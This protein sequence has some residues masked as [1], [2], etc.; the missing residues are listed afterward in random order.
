[1]R[2][3]ELGCFRLCSWIYLWRKEGSLFC[4]VV[5]MRFTELGCFRLCSWIYLWR[6]VV[7]FFCSYYEIHRTGMLQIVFLNLS[8]KE[9][10]LFCFVVMRFTELGCFRS[11]SWCLWK[12]LDEE[13]C[14]G[15][16]SMTFALA[17]QKLLNIEW[18]L[19][20]KLNW[21]VLENFRGIGMC[22]LVLLERSWWAGF[23][24]N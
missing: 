4:F 5:I 2:F 22:L 24:G 17:V 3:A 6:K 10:S 7:C 15:L 9:C 8:M 18:F 19:H 13:G 21:T 20:W 16:G 11:C 12:A 14:M 23:I 1:M